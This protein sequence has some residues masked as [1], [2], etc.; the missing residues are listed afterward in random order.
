MTTVQRGVVR[1]S[2]CSNETDSRQVSP[3]P[4]IALAMQFPHRA[5]KLGQSSPDDEP[6]LVLTVEI[7]KKAKVSVREKTIV[8]ARPAL[9]RR[10]SIP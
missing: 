3:L 6:H 2:Q 7:S 10:R 4:P 8:Q 9:V 1:Q 5:T